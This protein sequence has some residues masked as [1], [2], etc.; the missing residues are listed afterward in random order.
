MLKRGLERNIDAKFVLMRL[1]RH[2]LWRCKKQANMLGL[3]LF[4][5]ENSFVNQIG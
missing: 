2:F 1:L 4:P 5:I 3:A